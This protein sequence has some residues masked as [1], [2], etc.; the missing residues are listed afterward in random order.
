MDTSKIEVYYSEK[1]DANKDLND[2]SNGWT[3]DV[4]DLS[5]VKSYL[6]VLQDKIEASGTVEFNYEIELPDNIGYNHSA[7]TMYKIYYT[8]EAAEATMAEEK[9]APILNLTTGQGPELE[10]SISSTAGED[11]R[12]FNGQ[13]VRYYVEVKNT[14]D[15]EATNAKLNI[16]LPNQA[17]FVSYQEG[18]NIMDLT[19]ATTQS[20]EL[21][22]IKPGE[23]KEA[24]FEIQVNGHT[25]TPEEDAPE[26]TE[27]IINLVVK[28]A[29][30]N[31]DGEIKSNEYDLKVEDIGIFE[32]FNGVSTQEARTYLNGEQVTYDIQFHNKTME[33]VTNSVLTVPIPTDATMGDVKVTINNTE[34]TDGINIQTD[35]VVI[36]LGNLESNA[37]FDVKVSYSLGANSPAEISTK[38]SLDSDLGLTLYSNERIIHFGQVEMTVEQVKPTEQYVKERESFRYV[39]K[40]TA[41]G[42]TNLY[43]ATIVDTLPPE[44]Y[45][46]T[47]TAEIINYN[48]SGENMSVATKVEY[49][50][51]KVTVE[52][53][54]IFQGGDS[55]G[56]Y[57]CSRK[58]TS[59]QKMTAKH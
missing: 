43:H 49:K 29:A 7:A 53:S 32:F 21:G 23:T 12:V 5:K 38:V 58:T 55:R 48:G 22:T 30:D 39:F 2:A 33:T 31:I 35:K 4:Q 52:V 9:Q 41:S 50:D 40:I 44:V 17:T 10:I 45:F 14:G 54:E 24:S 28:V 15:L 1:A 37:K 42:E 34:K 20:I 57:I 25:E 36:N 56:M 8:N 27:K 3:K 16:D 47:A 26:Q 46:S 19:D 6:I 51:G 11:G 18:V 13:Y 59:S